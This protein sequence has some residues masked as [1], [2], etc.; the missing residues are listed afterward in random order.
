MKRF[1]QLD[2]IR[3][4][5]IALVI[6]Q[7]CWSIIDL[8]IPA[9]TFSYHGY[10]GLIYGVPLFVML[11]GFFQLNSKVKSTGSYLGGRFK[12]LLPPF[13]IWMIVTYAISV[14]VHKYDEISSVGDAFRL[15]VPFFLT[16]KV[17]EAFWYIFMI[18]GLYL[19]TP[20]LQH[21]LSNNENSKKLLEYGLILWAGWLFLSDFLPQFELLKQ[22]PIAGKFLGYY[23][24]GFY[25]C[26]YM[27]DRS[28]NIKVGLI[29]FVVSYG[30]NVFLM[31]QGFQL[32]TLEAI[33][34]VSAFI[35]LK[36]VRMDEGSEKLNTVI[37]R[38]SRYSYTIYL[39]HFIF[40]RLF[41]TYLP[42]YFPVHWATPIYTTLL[43][44]V[45]EYFFCRVLEWIPFIPDKLVG[46]STQ[47]IY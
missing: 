29:A 47:T 28:L 14:Y 23:L 30:L 25:A 44:L 2:L 42:D 15:F 43:V 35:V 27:N 7:H 6:F 5:A 36:S 13:F 9:Q 3:T 4:I 20:F 21:A 22:F 8:D 16:N 10:R 17:N 32:V 33:E 12:R 40:I 31:Y 46:I 26:S 45:V 1:L 11:S 37:T 39:T 34:V 38:I 18:S 24:A 19:I 41:Y